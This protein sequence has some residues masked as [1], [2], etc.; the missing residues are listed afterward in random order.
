ML[1]MP[2]RDY[3]MGGRLAGSRWRDIGGGD[4]SRLPQSGASLLGVGAVLPGQLAS[5]GQGG[6]GIHL[7]DSV[8]RK[9]LNNLTIHIA[10]LR[11]SGQSRPRPNSHVVQPISG[12]E[13]LNVS[14]AVPVTAWSG[15]LAPTPVWCGVGE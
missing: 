1:Q 5:Q 15:P 14:T 11:G 10:K 4:L 13:I 6:V 2:L 9:V 8:T 12:L 7:R 3:A